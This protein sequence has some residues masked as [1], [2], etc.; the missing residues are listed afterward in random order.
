GWRDAAERQVQRLARG[1]EYRAAHR[2]V[3]RTAAFAELFTLPAELLA[4]PTGLCGSRSR[5]DENHRKD[6]RQVMSTCRSHRDRLPA[7]VDLRAF[8]RA[9][10]RVA[11]FLAAFLATFFAAFFAVLFVAAFALSVVTLFFRCPPASAA[12]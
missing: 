3:E 10:F 12:R 5:G 6:D 4:D 11:A 1:Q 9:G 8:A 7:A 2:A